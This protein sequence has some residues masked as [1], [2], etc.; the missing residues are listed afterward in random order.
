MKFLVAVMM[1][2]AAHQVCAQTSPEIAA[3]LDRARKSTDQNDDRK[4]A[5]AAGY[6][7]AGRD[8]P[9]MGE[10]WINPRILMNGGL[11]AAKPAVLT[12][13]VIGERPVLT[14][15]VY[16]VSLNPGEVP[17]SAFGTSA[18]WH[19]HNG[20]IDDEALLP[21]HSTTPSSADGTRVA[22]LHVWLR[23]PAPGG[24]FAA[25][26]W[27]IPFV[28]AGLKV[29]DEFPNGAARA[30]S[31]VG[32]GIDFYRDLAGSAAAPLISPAL[33]EC[34]RFASSIVGAARSRGGTITD[35]ELRQLDDKW[36]ETVHAVSQLA[37]SEAARMIN[38]GIAAHEH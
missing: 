17:P 5:I 10:H 23:I 13:L 4:F 29:P 35:L 20:A 38:G 2:F 34:E 36:S 21:E 37:G 32:G 27:A 11:D 7:K 6:R 25:E 9:S 24:I 19:E 3:L 1:L 22:F 33:S 31:L 12:Y 30:V 16:A 18:H 28:R 8:M 26:N 15:V 14:G